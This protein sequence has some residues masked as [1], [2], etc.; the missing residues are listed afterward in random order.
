MTRSPLT[1][2]ALALALTGLACDDKPAPPP[3]ERKSVMEG[4]KAESEAGRKVE[5][6]KQ[7]IEGAERQLEERSDRV[8]EQSQGEQGARG[9]P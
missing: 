9:V 2:L 8:F 1:L 5:R 6:A 7:D 4:G 3:A